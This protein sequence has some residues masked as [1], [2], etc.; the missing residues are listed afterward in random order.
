MRQPAHSDADGL[1]TPASPPSMDDSC[2]S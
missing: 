2:I 1:E